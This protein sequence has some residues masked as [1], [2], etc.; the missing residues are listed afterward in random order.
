MLGYQN[1]LKCCRTSGDI[2]IPC[3][4]SVLAFL[5]ETL[6]YRVI[7]G[8]CNR[9]SHEDSNSAGQLM[10]RM[11]AELPCRL[12]RIIKWFKEEPRRLGWIITASCFVFYTA[13]YSLMYGYSLL[14]TEFLHEF[15]AKVSEISKLKINS[16]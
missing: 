10:C 15:D 6:S 5:A 16:I 12:A 14:F 1:I 7:M 2:I 13:S 4:H 11:N 3:H 8:T 9:S